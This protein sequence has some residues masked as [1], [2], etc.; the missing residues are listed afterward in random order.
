M[1]AGDGTD[2]TQVAIQSILPRANQLEILVR[3]AELHRGPAALELGVATPYVIARLR[4][5]DLPVVVL[6][7][8]APDTYPP[9]R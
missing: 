2:R 6:P 4:R 9:G 5:V 1:F 8:K 3:I 7:A